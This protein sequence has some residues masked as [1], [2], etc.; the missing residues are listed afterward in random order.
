MA[1]TESKILRV[2]LVKGGRVVQERLL[3]KP[4]AISVGTSDRCTFQLAVEG[5]PAIYPLIKVSPN[6]YTLQFTPK[7]DGKLTVNTAGGPKALDFKS[8]SETG[9]SSTEGKLE[10]IKLSPTMRGKINIGEFTLLFQFISPRPTQVVPPLP[11]SYRRFTLK[12]LDFAFLNIFILSALFQGGSFLYLINQEVEVREL[13]AQE[14]ADLYVE[15]TEEELI[16]DEPPPEKPEVEPDDANDKPSKDTKPKIEKVPDPTP[17]NREQRKQII[18]RNVVEKTVLKSLF[19]GNDSG[20]SVAEELAGGA[21]EAINSAFD[22]TQL[23]F[24][25]GKRN[26]QRTG[27]MGAA[28]GKTTTIDDRDIGGGGRAAVKIRRKR[29]KKIKSRIKVRKPDSAVGLGQLDPTKIQRVV[30]RNSRRL[31]GCYESELKKDP[32]LQ[33]VVKV[34]FTIE[35]T[36]RVSKSKTIQNSMGSSAVAKCIENNIKRWRFKS[37]PKGGSV[38]IAYPF[39]FTPSS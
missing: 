34:R 15:M 24:S 6:G 1:K 19:S 32:T 30:R 38:T 37:K 25:G 3:N 14:I 17:E 5:L 8:I 11:K 39:Y 4:Q 29:E 10:V 33:G 7:M 2:G 35:V 12:S 26:T 28:Q 20:V 27:L 18:R 13:S 22:G 31:Q 9:L 23:A 21:N 36:G 16:K